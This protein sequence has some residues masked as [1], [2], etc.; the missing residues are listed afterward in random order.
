MTAELNNLVDRQLAKNPKDFLALA[1]RAQDIAD[2]VSRNTETQNWDPAI[3]AYK[4][5]LEASD[6]SQAF[7]FAGLGQCLCKKAGLIEVR[8][9]QR[10]LFQEALPLLEKARDLD[11]DNN[12]AWAYFLYVCYGSVFS[13]NDS[14]AIEIKDKFGF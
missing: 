5:L 1:Y 10:A 2:K 13:Y 11:P 4:A 12:T 3:E 7:V 8:A 14:R 9:E 6:G